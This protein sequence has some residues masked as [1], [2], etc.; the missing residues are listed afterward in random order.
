MTNK[1]RP[2]FVAIFF[3]AFLIVFG[4]LIVGVI[5]IFRNWHD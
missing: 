4:G 5:Y 3:F 1:I 2:I